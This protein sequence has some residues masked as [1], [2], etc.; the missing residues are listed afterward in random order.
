MDRKQGAAA[1]LLLA[2]S[3]ALLMS[4]VV[5]RG[6]G[7]APGEE[8]PAA[9]GAPLSGI[10]IAIDPGHG[11]YDQGCESARG[12]LEAPL[13]LDVSLRVRDALEGLGAYVVMTRETDTSLV[14]PD[15]SGNRKKQDM[16]LR[17][18]V[19]RGCEAQ[20]L[21]SIHM[22]F[23]TASGPSGALTYYREGSEDGATLASAIQNAFHSADGRHKKTAQSGDY[24]MLGTCEAS[25]LVECGFLSNPRE[26]ALLATEAY[27]QQVAEIIAQGVLAYWHPM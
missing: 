18:E 12:T 23:Y 5:T 17:E 7:F 26:E 25:V 20:M 16:A 2:L 13:N 1:I 11:G 10:T 6:E 27:R 21:L 4:R 24:F 9:L 8:A 22:N 3:F 19:V 14:D 15:A